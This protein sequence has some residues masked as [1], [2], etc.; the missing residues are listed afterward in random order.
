MGEPHGRRSYVFMA[1][2]LLVFG[3]VLLVTEPGSR[4]GFIFLA[5]SGG[6]GLFS[7]FPKVRL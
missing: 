3:I 2:I 6:L 1:V 7:L 5:N 4:T